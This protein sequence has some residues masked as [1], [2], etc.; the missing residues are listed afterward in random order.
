MHSSLQKPTEQKQNQ[1]TYMTKRFVASSIDEIGLFFKK[2]MGFLG[3]SFKRGL[4][5]TC[6]LSK[7][8]AFEQKKVVWSAS[9]TE[10]CLFF[11][12]V[13]FVVQN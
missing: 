5:L 4:T 13:S 12:W 1:K 7:K 3:L 9:F 8:K 2:K 6:L 11:F 10:F